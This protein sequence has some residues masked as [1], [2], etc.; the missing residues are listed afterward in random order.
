MFFS[1][2]TLE[3]MDNPE[4]LIRLLFQRIARKM[5]NQKLDLLMTV[6]SWKK[7]KLMEKK[8]DLLRFKIHENFGFL[9]SF[10]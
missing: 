1:Q 2:N 4:Q 3:K 8:M 5:N 10:C 6:Y 7:E 9:N